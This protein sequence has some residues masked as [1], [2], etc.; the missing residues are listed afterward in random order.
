MN[1]YM[2]WNASAAID[3]NSCVLGLNMANPKWIISRT[4][5]LTNNFKKSPCDHVNYVNAYIRIHFSFFFL[6]HVIN[7]LLKKTWTK[8]KLHSC[9]RNTNNRNELQTNTIKIKQTDANYKTLYICNDV[10]SRT[11]KEWMNRNYEYIVSLP[12]SL[13]YNVD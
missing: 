2:S 1:H 10:Y 8:R 12:R 7:Y 13:F 9:R 6:S 3:F 11:S 4:I 5:D